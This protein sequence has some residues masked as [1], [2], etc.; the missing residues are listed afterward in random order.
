MSGSSKCPTSRDLRELLEGEVADSDQ[1]A[2]VSHLDRCSSCQQSLE[3]LANGDGSL[4]KTLLEQPVALRR[5][6]RL[7][8]TGP[9]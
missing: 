4:A 5:P 6:T 9:L 7:P 2:V 3:A 8:L 1:A